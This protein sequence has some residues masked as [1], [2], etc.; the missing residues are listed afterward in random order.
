M[1]WRGFLVLFGSGLAA[2]AVWLLATA[3]FNAGVAMQLLLAVV[4]I[5]FGCSRRLSGSRWLSLPAIGLVAVVAIVSAFLA[6]FGLVDD[7]DYD[8]SAVVVLGAAVHGST[9]SPSLAQRL[10]VAVDYHERNPAALVVVTGGQGPQ[11]SLPEAVAAKAYLA[12][13]GVPESVI[14]VE[15]RSTST[16][17]NFELAKA[18][19]DARLKPGYRIA[20]VTNEYH[21]WRASRTAAAA[22]LDAHHLHAT[23]RWYVWPSSYL[24]ES[25]AA[26]LSWAD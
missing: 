22:G 2:N 14:V 5:A 25:A 9:V 12:Q 26:L 23:T 16:A 13:R 10:D 18:L 7:A 4:L 3:N 6:S 11:E 24:R 1:V 20:F 19:L 21:V 8:E 17:E 15:D